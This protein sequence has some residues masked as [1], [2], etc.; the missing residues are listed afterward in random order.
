MRLNNHTAIALL[1][2]V[3]LSVELIADTVEQVLAQLPWK[4]WWVVAQGYYVPDFAIC[5]TMMGIILAAIALLE[6]QNI[7]D[8]IKSLW[9][10]FRFFWV[11]RKYKRLRRKSAVKLKKS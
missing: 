11:L 8:A 9:R 5:M 4:S 10:K 2:V 1:V 6:L 7:E 3:E